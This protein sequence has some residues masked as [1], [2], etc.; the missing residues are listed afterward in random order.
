MS[1]PRLVCPDALRPAGTG[2]TLLG[3]RCRACGE[4][5]FPVTRACARCCGTDVE[6]CA[7]GDRGSLWSWTVQGFPPKA[8]YDGGDGSDS[9]RPF[10]VGYVQLA[11]GLKVEARLTAA[12]PAQL[13]IGMPMVLVAEPYRAVPG[14]ETVL[15]YAFAPAGASA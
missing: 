4:Q 13:R 1:A 15:T 5:F 10:G 12:D 3:S 6:D 11:S 9:F 2:W 14:G 7:L 8:P